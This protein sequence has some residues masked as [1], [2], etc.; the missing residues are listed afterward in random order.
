MRPPH[1]LAS[2]SLVFTSRF[3]PQFI[4]RHPA[5]RYRMANTSPFGLKEPSLVH[6]Q[7]Y[8]DG[9]WLD[10]NEGAVIKVTNPATAEELGTVPEM[11][12]AET[13][14]AIDAASRAFKTWSKTTAKTLENGKPFAEAKGEKAYSA[15]FVEWFGKRNSQ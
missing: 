6:H 14:Q 7:A 15:L 11:G 2:V 13:K 8:I 5:F 3:K 1:R 4:P 9:K 12:L 10:A